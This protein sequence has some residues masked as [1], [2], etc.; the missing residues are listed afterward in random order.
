MGI[1]MLGSSIRLALRPNI[2]LK[3]VLIGFRGFSSELSPDGSKKTLSIDEALYLAQLGG[4]S[5]VKELQQQIMNSPSFSSNKSPF[6]VENFYDTLESDEADD[7]LEISP[8]LDDISGFQEA[9]TREYSQGLENS[10]GIIHNLL[11]KN[12]NPN[13]VDTFFYQGHGKPAR[14]FLVESEGVGTRRRATAHVVLRQGTGQVRFLKDGKREEQIYHRISNRL[15][16]YARFDLLQPLFETG[17]CGAFDV[18]ID[19]KGGG[20]VG[21]ALAARLAISRALL[22]ACPDTYQDLQFD[23]MLMEDTRQRMPKMIGRY[24]ARAAQHWSKR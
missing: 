5:T 10:D 4:V 24:S 11:K 7:P 23:D 9:S 18:F 16:L 20:P 21:Q 22:K 17:T 8:E 19:A 12:F 15:F 2:G 1:G 13:K 3:R 6:L 14:E